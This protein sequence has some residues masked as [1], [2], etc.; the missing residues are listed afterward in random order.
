MK[1][2]IFTSN[3]P[4]EEIIHHSQTAVHIQ[5][6]YAIQEFLKKHD[7]SLQIIFDDSRKNTVL[8]EWE[9]ILI[10]KLNRKIKI[11]KPIFLSKLVFFDKLPNF[12]K[13]I[14]YTNN[15]YKMYKLFFYKKDYFKNLKGE[16]DFFVSYLSPESVALISGYKKRKLTFEGDLH[17]QSFSVSLQNVQANSI[18]KKLIN[19]YSKFICRIWKS[20]YLLLLKD[21]DKIFFANLN[22]LNLLKGKLAG[23][24]IG[25]LWP[26]SKFLKKYKKK[27]KLNIIL[28]VGN[29]SSSS[30]RNAIAY[31]TKKLIPVIN[32]RINYSNLNFILISSGLLTNEEKDSFSKINTI[33]KGWVEDLDKELLDCDIF[34]FLNNSGPIKAIF[35]RQIYAWSLGL[36]VLGHIDGLK[37]MTQMKNNYNIML[38][39]DEV[40]I[41]EQMKKLINSDVLR[42][43]IGLNGLKTYRSYF[44]PQKHTNN[45]LKYIETCQ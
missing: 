32:K 9:K 23:H 38:G 41:V 24:F 43:K 3:I 35:S 14:I 39:Q 26:E 20:I 2:L 18:K 22:S 21:F 31:V 34:V 37:T 42:E 1:I 4:S 33:M 5:C 13:K 15:V 29:V 16:Y 11:L 45:I 40:K 36:C 27:K 12:L 17:Y 25:T 30:N 28:G 44:S 8:E 7:I 10:S 6:F 19:F